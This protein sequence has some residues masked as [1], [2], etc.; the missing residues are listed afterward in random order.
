MGLGSMI[1]ASVFAAVVLVTAINLR[2]ITRTARATRVTVTLV[3]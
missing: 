3:T 1:G 2:G